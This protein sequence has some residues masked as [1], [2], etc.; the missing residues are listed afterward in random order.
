MADSKRV[1]CPLS[2]KISLSV[3]EAA[4]LLS[5]S[6]RTVYGWLGKYPDFPAVRIGGR[7]LISRPALQEWFAGQLQKGD[8]VHG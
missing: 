7:L 5:V 3:R 4:E 6:D 8:V 1:P 2:E